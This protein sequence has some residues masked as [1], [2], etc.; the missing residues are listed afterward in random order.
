MR[1]STIGTD[2]IERN[3]VLLESFLILNELRESIER[4]GLVAEIIRHATKRNSCGV[5]MRCLE[6]GPDIKD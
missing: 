5:D 6:C 4:D 2:S 3:P 1:E